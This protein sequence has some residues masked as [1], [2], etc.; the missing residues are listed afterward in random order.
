MR[1]KGLLSLLSALLLAGCQAASNS[2]TPNAKSGKSAAKAGLLDAF[3][4][5]P[6]VVP[7]GTTLH[8][9]LETTLSS[10]TNRQGDAVLAKLADDVRV[11]DKVVLPGGTELR[12]HVTA[13]VP[14][15]RVKG[16]AR[17]AFDFDGVVVGGKTHP[18]E[19]RAIDIT[20]D[21]THKRDAAIVG[22]GTAGGAIIGALTGGKKGAGIGALIG[23]AAGTGV[24]L[25]NQGNEVEIPSGTQLGV[26]LTGDARLG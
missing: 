9:V 10:N 6:V 18:I 1:A 22:G 23:A 4:T 14:S 2:P 7:E 20:A 24:V 19:T 17:L 8:L 15:G 3:K 26:K 12:G 13:A 21:N 16:L 5:Q 25:T 11:G